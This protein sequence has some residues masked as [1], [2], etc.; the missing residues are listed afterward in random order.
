MVRSGRVRFY[1]DLAALMR[2]IDDVQP[3]PYN[4][5]NGDVEAITESIVDNGMYGA[6]L[7]QR[8]T[9]YIVR[10]NHTW[11]ACKELG[12]EVVPV[13]V[14]DVDD[15]R[16]K[17][18]MVADNQTAHL[19][20]PDTG[21]LLELLH[22][23]EKFDPNGLTGSGFTKTDVDTLEYLNQIELDTAERDFAQWPTFSVQVHPN[24]LRAFR[25]ITRE[26]DTDAQ[27]F[28]LLLRVAGWDGHE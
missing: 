15:I 26:A 5:N 24:V 7:V 16:A 21:L 27:A 10:G 25:H 18:M 20:K 23:V 2:P 6:V 11:L 14:V 12:S 13:L 1:P 8:S 3:A 4:Y 9:G 19:A 28:E 17:K 22:E